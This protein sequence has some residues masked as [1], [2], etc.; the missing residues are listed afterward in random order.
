MSDAPEP[1][2]PRLR[3]SGVAKSFHGV[4]VLSDVGLEVGAGEVV[5]LLGENGAGKSTLIKIL[6]GLY[7]ADAG[8]V[9]VDGAPLV[10]SRPADAERVGIRVVHQERHLAG[11]LTV[12][13]QLYLGHPGQRRTGRRRNRA[14]AADL[15]RLVGL[16]VDP[17]TLVDDLTVAEQQLLQIAIATLDRPRVLILDEPT[18][19]LAARE[20]D[21]LF[22]TIQALSADGVGIIYISHYLQEVR[23]IAS[24]VVVLRNGR[25]AGGYALDDPAATIDAIVQLMVGRHVQEFGGDA[26]AQQPVGAPA[27]QLDGLGVPGRLAP[28]DLTVH[29]G[30]IVGITGLV[31]SG[32]EELAEAVVALQPGTGST[33]IGDR[34]VRSPRGFVAAGGAYVPANRRRDGILSRYTIAENITLASLGSVTDWNGLIQRGREARAASELIASVDIR[35]ARPSAVAEDLSGGNQQKVVL[36]RWLQAG[37]RVFVLDQ[38]TSGVDIGSR[39]QLYARVRELVDDGAAVL[40][41]TLDAEELI[42]LSDRVLVLYRGEVVADLPR[43]DATIEG[44]LALS[45]SGGH[46]SSAGL[47][48]GEAA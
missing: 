22:E 47:S 35:P 30:E 17:T 36:A 5:A 20:V 34:V 43:G 29:R 6:T 26:S 3:A 40:L 45:T 9:E 46:A 41:V 24:R 8:E 2:P 42:G 19:P 25:N 10:I 48:D 28:L 31:G 33:R 38:P 4:S 18:A 13:E 7:T 27:L 11:R 16:E 12:A 21:R 32:I 39:A 37:S 44:V 15:Q 23:R 1:A 14:A